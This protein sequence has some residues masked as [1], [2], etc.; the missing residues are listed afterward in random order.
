MRPKRT[1]TTPVASAPKEKTK[2]VQALLTENRIFKPS[3]KFKEQAHITDTKIYEKAKK[4]PQAFW[5]KQSQALD[6]FQEWNKIL[7]WKPPFAKWFVGGKLNACYN[8]V[9]RHI[10]SKTRNKAAL[11]W[12]GE[13]GDQRT[14]TYY[15]LYRE[16]NKLANV[17]KSL[18]VKRGD[19]VAIYLPLIPE[20]VIS[21][22]A[23]ARIGAVHTVVF[24]GFSADSLRDRI[25][26]ASAKLVITADGGYRRGNVLPL[27]A[28]ADE[29][30]KNCPTIKNVIV[31]QRTKNEVTMQEGRDH[32]Y[33]D[34]VKDAKSFCEP[35]KMDSEDL[36]FILYTSGTTGK[37]K[38][39]I[40]TTGGY[41]TGVTFT[42]K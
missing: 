13:P 2:T 12:E 21:M 5:A 38:G 19:R 7:D 35:E 29:A 15:D 41:M 8:C 17:I 14:L 23:C 31:V 10:E 28:A 30:I 11:I 3:Q 24:G 36:L 22:L 27:K 25:N 4:N 33:H 42:T 40:H 6:W 20:A 1:K 32:W 34:L 26:D 16:V 9:D 37:P 39:I 18:G